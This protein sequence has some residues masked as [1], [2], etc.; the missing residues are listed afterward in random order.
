MYSVDMKTQLELEDERHKQPLVTIVIVTWNSA[1]DIDECLISMLA[2]SYANYQIL[3]V[4]SDSSDETLD[5]VR[6]RYPAVQICE[7]G[8]NLGYRRGNRVGMAVAEGEYIV[9]CND[10]VRVTEH[11]LEAMIV[12]ME[13]D[14]TIGIATPLILE[15]DRPEEISAAGNTLHYSGMSGHIQSRGSHRESIQRR[16]IVAA[17]SGCCFMI[18]KGLLVQLGGFSNDFEQYDT[19]FHASL[20]E[21]DLGWRA[22][23]LGYTVQVV[24]ES[25]LYHKHKWNRMHPNRFASREWGRYIV[26]LRN[27]KRLTIALLLPVLVMIEVMTTGLAAAKGPQWLK[28]KWDIWVWMFGHPGELR[29]MRRNVQSSRRVSDLTIVNRMSPTLSFAYSVGYG[30]AGTVLNRL[31]D[32]LFTAYFGVLRGALRVLERD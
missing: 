4:D 19:G 32:V 9:V 3:I 14:P 13:S 25:I 7:L 11:W 29:A 10:D 28:K 18:R 8:Q 20:E 21:V 12:A 15:Y 2:Q 31:V 16:Q 30:K 27:Y 24:P 17:P 1:D 23:L 5:V 26:V 22:Q 6:K